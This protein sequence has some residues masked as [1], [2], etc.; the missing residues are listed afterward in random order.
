MS[1]VE[2]LVEGVIW[3]LAFSLAGVGFLY[4][5]SM[6]ADVPQ[7]TEIWY[8]M[9]ISDR[10]DDSR[11]SREILE[12]MLMSCVGTIF[13]LGCGFFF[14][15]LVHIGLET[16]VGH[17][18][19]VSTV[20]RYTLWLLTGYILISPFVGALPSIDKF[21]DTV[22]GFRTVV[23]ATSISLLSLLF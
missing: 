22:V 6:I 18:V 19:P 21:D 12:T 10:T 23:L 14:V 9:D 15:G 11:R 8:F 1:V 16:H 20:I 13:V 3:G 4:G 7:I 2:L 17:W 5:I